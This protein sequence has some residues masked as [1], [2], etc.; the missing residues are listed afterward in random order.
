MPV[1]PFKWDPRSKA[2]NH[3]FRLAIWKASPMVRFFS[4]S[5]YI[6]LLTLFMQFV[7]V[8]MQLLVKDLD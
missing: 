2:K 3:M 4:E 6:L 7:L 1:D 8:E 5:V